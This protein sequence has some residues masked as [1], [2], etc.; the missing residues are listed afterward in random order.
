MLQPTVLILPAARA[1]WEVWKGARGGDA[2]WR[3]PAESPAQAATGG[4]AMVIGLPARACRTFA[5]TVPTEDPKLFRQLAFAQVE[6]RGLAAG[7]AD[8]TAFTCHVH[9]KSQG[10]SVLSVDV[11][12][13]EGAALTLPARTHGLL[14]AVR[15]YPLPA[16]RLVVLEEQGRLVLCAGTGGQ[17]VHS[18][19]ISGASG[20]DAHVGQ[21]LRVASL[22]LPQQGLMPEVSGVEAWGDFPA[23]EAAALS[24]Q[25]GLPVE[26]RP[27]PAPVLR[28]EQRRT[29]AD[30]LPPSIRA[31]ARNR[32]R[33]PL[34][35]IAAAAA[36]AAVTALG[37]R[38]QHRLHELEKEA[39]RLE[40]R[41]NASAGEVGRAE[42]EQSKLRELQA[43]WSALRPAVEPRRYPLRQLNALARCLEASAAVLTRFESKPDAVSI[44]GTARSAGD[45][46]TLYNTI[47]AEPDLGLHTWSMVQP[48]LAA[49][50]TAT[51]V[52]TGKP[53]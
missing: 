23:D 10:H 39:A 28:A 17:L 26:V 27:R 25:I 34:G 41:V 46:Y 53:R 31:Q 42:G 11:V 36:V 50:G 16:N 35:W 29:S 30:L 15:L 21:E 8:E 38:Q 45:A 2:E 20:L 9:E 18:Q 37:W 19:V 24:R 32:R 49:D 14:P 22:A 40:A 52:I 4:G 44:G 6:R 7:P 3:G 1:H 33:R 51:F 48:N 13:A 5:F 47:R 43:Q 12:L